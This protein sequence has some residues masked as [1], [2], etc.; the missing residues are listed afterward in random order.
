MRIEIEKN[1]TD[2]SVIRSSMTQY[3]SW[4]CRSL[5]TSRLCIIF[6]NKNI[7]LLC[8]QSDY[9]LTMDKEKPQIPGPSRSNLAKDY[10]DPSILPS[11][12]SDLKGCKKCEIHQNL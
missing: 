5:L 2:C 8:Q 6:S 12:V 4:L 9:L 7:F 3:F 11:A 1:T 10:E